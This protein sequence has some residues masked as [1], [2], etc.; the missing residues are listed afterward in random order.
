MI[1][2]NFANSKLKSEIM[3][4]QFFFSKQNMY[5]YADLKVIKWCLFVM[6][7]LLIFFNNLEVIWAL[8]SDRK[9]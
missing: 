9:C 3:I 1:E 4:G 7:V 2:E 8:I 6:C 5:Q